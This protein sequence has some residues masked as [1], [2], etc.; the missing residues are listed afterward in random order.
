MF[1]LNQ[2]ILPM[3]TIFDR[4]VPSEFRGKQTEL[5]SSLSLET[6]E[7]AAERFKYIS[8][9]LLSPNHWQDLCG[10]LS[11]KFTLVDSSGNQLERL[12]AVGD[13]IQINLPGPSS[14]NGDGFDWVKVDAIEWGS[15]DSSNQSVGIRIRPCS[16]P[17]NDEEEVAHF[18]EPSATGTYILHQENNTITAYY[19]GK[20]E[21]TNKSTDKMLDNIRNTLV[22]SV[23]ILGVSEIQWKIFITKLLEQTP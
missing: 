10:K 20:N 21:V 17:L 3:D 1:Q 5:N 2:I 15:G 4:I 18:F 13:Y 7:I 23:G 11:P 14:S 8:S 16:N 12:A 19:Y 22:A 9:I 6:N